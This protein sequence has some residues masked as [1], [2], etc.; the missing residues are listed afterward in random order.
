MTSIQELYGELWAEESALERELGRSLEPRG[1]DWLFETFAALGPKAGEL[2][3]DVGSRDAAH[4]IRL[5]RE[6][7]LRAI[8][9]DPV[10]LH[11]ERARRA[12]AE[13][14]LEDGVEIVEAGIEAMPLADGLADWIWCR[15]VL[16]HVDLDRGFAECARILR[17]GGRM[18]A[19]VTL[20]TERLEP[21]EAKRLFEALAIVPESVDPAGL[22]RH[23]SA[24][25]LKL[26][27]S[28]R[29][30]GEWRERMIEDGT[31]EPGNDLVRLS[32]LRRRQVELVERYGERDVAAREAGKLWGVYQLI[33]K[34]CPTVYLWERGA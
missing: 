34:L 24:A 19:Y 6:H 12:V 21:R 18:L 31:W 33:G 20:T 25:G 4:T 32:R 29:L 17:P 8:A 2:V 13:A 27:S 7:G 10:P 11:A 28:T 30:E 9:L 3:V 22:E 26:I 14:G 1:T 16:V 15:D 5:A 23:A